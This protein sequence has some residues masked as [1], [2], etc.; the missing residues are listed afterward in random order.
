[1]TCRNFRYDLLRGGGGNGSPTSDHRRTSFE[2]AA[3]VFDRKVPR[4]GCTRNNRILSL[5]PFEHGIAPSRYGGIATSIDGERPALMLWWFRRPIRAVPCS[6]RARER[7]YSRTSS[8]D[9]SQSRLLAN[10]RRIS[11][12][13]RFR[14]RRGRVR[15]NN[16]LSGSSR[17]PPLP[18]RRP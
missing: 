14:S 7:Q 18:P 5:P 11:R 2:T 1:M 12:L 15:A 9:R 10:A 6:A 16:R 17:S 8:P 3:P 4:A 13:P